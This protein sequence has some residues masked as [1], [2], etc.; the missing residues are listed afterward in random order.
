MKKP[1]LCPIAPVAALWLCTNLLSAQAQI[2]NADCLEC[3]GE[4]DA[5]PH[6]N[7][8]LFLRS[9]HA[10][11]ECTSCHDDVED[12]MHDTPLKKVNCS[13]CHDIESEIYLQS[14]H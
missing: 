13:D 2:S 10:D 14:S 4:A 6:V 11:N 7:A 9:V 3:H 1:R 12:A 8:E 5:E